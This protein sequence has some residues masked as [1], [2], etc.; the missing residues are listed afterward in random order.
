[1]KLAVTDANIFIDLFQIDCLHYLFQLKITLHTTIE[2]LEELHEHQKAEVNKFVRT[3]QLTVDYGANFS[4]EIPFILSPGLAEADKSV[5]Y[6]AYYLNSG[7]LT[8][9]NKLKKSA[10]IHFEVHGI[11]WLLDKFVDEGY[12]SGQEASVKLKSLIALK[13]RLPEKECERLL[14]K[15]K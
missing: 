13:C 11:L 4:K 3:R 2:V 1:M 7:I 6:Y 12:L 15:W 5:F 14:N 10:E 8:G 9:D